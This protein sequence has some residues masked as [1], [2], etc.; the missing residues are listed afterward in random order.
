MASCPYCGS[1][2]ASGPPWAPGE[3]HRLAFDP[4]K[5]RLWNVCTGCSR[6]TLT[7]LESRWETL[8]A[9]EEAVRTQG[10]VRLSTNH[11]ILARVDEGDL[12]RVGT[13]PRL[14]FADWR[15]G[16][17]S[18]LARRRPGFWGRL[19][20]RLPAPPVG[21]YDPYRGFEGAIR[22]EP[23]LA[24][25]FVG[26]ASSLTYLFSQVPLAPGCPSCRGP[27]ALEP[28]DFQ[29]LEI[30]SGKVLPRLVASCALCATEVTMDLLEARPVLRVGLALVTPP[31][32]VRNAASAVAS[33][34]DSIGGGIPFLQAISTSR[35]RVGELDVLSRTG[36]IMSLD[37]LAEAEALEAEWRRAEEMAAIMDG[38]LSEIPGFEAFRHRILEE[39]S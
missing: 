20:S 8:E 32:H 17:K 19:L 39:G 33:E 5:G 30:I 10:K 21:G 13:P 23:W 3:G 12:I 36:L 6:W 34:L 2:L 1:A 11:L 27:L 35:V 26:Q 31:D 15:Y 22:S 7:P 18:E 37:E 25:P 29:D 4:E 24:S 9:C 14:E 28:W 38:E 16:S